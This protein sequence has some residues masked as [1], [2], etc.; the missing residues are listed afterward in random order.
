[1]HAVIEYRTGEGFVYIHKGQSTGDVEIPAILPPPRP[2]PP[3]IRLGEKTAPHIA[4][5]TTQDD[6]PD[7]H[8]V[9]NL[10]GTECHYAL[11][12]NLN[13]SHPEQQDRAAAYA[14]PGMRSD[15]FEKIMVTAFGGMKA[16]HATL[17]HAA[18]K[19]EKEFGGDCCVTMA[20]LDPKEGKL[21]I[22]SRGDAAVYM[23][24]QDKQKRLPPVTACV[25]SE[26]TRFLQSIGEDQLLMGPHMIGRDLR[27]M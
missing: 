17:T 11:K 3:A 24:L 22:G 16:A 1:M 15:C 7:R 21:A 20:M 13:K 8:R 12:G 10:G 14:L 19:E 2:Q 23:V 25:S 18:L 26:Y 5:E 4:S 27:V 9:R 6:A